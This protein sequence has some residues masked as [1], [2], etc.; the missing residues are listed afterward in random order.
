MITAKLSLQ[1]LVNLTDTLQNI[2]AHI[3]QLRVRTHLRLVEYYL[4]QQPIDHLS[5]TLQ[6]ARSNNVDHLHRYWQTGIFPHNKDF[7]YRR[8]PYFKDAI[9]TPCAMAYLIEQSGAEALVDTVANNNNHVYI[10]DI[11]SGPVIDWIKQSGLTQTEAAKIQPT[12]GP[13]GA[14][15]CPPTHTTAT[16]TLWLIVWIISG[17]G[18]ILLE[19]L[20]YKTAD[21]LTQHQPLRRVVAWGYFTI[22]NICLLLLLYPNLKSIVS[23]IVR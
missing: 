22:I 16:T 14:M 18:F 3:E 1:P 20:S 21:W 2:L 11:Q 19:W 4:R 9:G 15:A 10:N 23:D 6:Q 12:Y 13:C 8:M 17:L 7:W 5:P